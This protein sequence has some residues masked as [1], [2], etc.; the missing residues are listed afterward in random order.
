MSRLAK[1]NAA[2]FLAGVFFAGGLDHVLFA[3]KGTPTSHYGL[4]VSP[5]AQ[6]AFSGF[7]FVVMAALISLHRRW[8]PLETARASST[9]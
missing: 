3:A 5:V 1:P 4:A 8:S 2:L 7:D 9:G 6:L